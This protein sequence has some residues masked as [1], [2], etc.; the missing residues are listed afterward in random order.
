[1]KILVADLIVPSWCSFRI[2]HAVN[3][4]STFPAPPPT[5]LYGLIAN[6]LGL[7]P[8]DYSLQD[9]LELNVGILDFGETV[10]TLSRWQKWNVSKDQWYTLLIKQ[11]IIQP[12]YRLYIRGEDELLNEVEA[13]LNQPARILYLGESDDM[14]EVYVKGIIEATPSQSSIIHNVLPLSAHSAIN[15]EGNSYVVRWPVRFL[16]EARSTAVQYEM[17]TIQKHFKLQNKMKCY[18]LPEIQQYIHLEGVL[19]NE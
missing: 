9:Q 5:T 11:K 2:P 4:H 6:A 18:Y 17:V 19:E 13:A 8:D 3:V 14:I 16:E 12:A 15:T 1:M 10:E 7:F